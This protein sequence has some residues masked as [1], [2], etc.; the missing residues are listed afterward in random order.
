M[1]S[2]TLVAPKKIRTASVNRSSDRKSLIAVLLGSA[3]AC[4]TP[5]PNPLLLLKGSLVLSLSPEVSPTALHAMVA[6]LVALRIR[7]ASRVV[8]LRE[9]SAAAPPAPWPAYSFPLT[10]IWAGAYL[11]VMELP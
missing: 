2:T 10:S 9:G 1:T 11:M 6:R 8:A 3:P 5:K 7:K 4:P